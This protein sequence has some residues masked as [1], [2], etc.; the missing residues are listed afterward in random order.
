MLQGRNQQFHYI[1]QYFDM[2]DASHVE[3]IGNSRLHSR[4][5]AEHC[6]TSQDT[7][8]GLVCGNHKPMPSNKIDKTICNI[9]QSNER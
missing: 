8:T 1:F 5:I 7:T 4:V 9:C 6:Q 3:V 2:Q